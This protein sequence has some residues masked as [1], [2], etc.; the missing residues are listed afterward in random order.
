[1]EELTSEE[2]LNLAKEIWVVKEEMDRLDQ[3]NQYIGWWF[4]HLVRII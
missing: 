4:W 3:E 2:Q 1:M